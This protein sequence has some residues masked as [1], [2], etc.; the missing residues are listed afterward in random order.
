MRH[1]RFQARG[2]AFTPQSHAH[3]DGEGSSSWCHSHHT[4]ITTIDGGIDVTIQIQQYFA[5]TQSHTSLNL[6]ANVEPVWHE[7]G[8]PGV[9]YFS[10]WI[11][12][13]G[14]WI[15]HCTVVC[16]LHPLFL[17]VACERER[18]PFFVMPAPRTVFPVPCS[19]ASIQ[20]FLACSFIWPQSPFSP[21]S[22]IVYW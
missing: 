22:C 18:F 13:D 21:I 14:Q 19:S 12:A 4:I 9:S 6:L 2:G 17:T 1:A 3:D 20:T 10:R 7:D 5:V 15:V 8:E 16:L 11:Q